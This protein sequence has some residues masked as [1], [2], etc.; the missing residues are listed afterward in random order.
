MSER[1]ANKKVFVFPHLDLINCFLKDEASATCNLESNIVQELILTHYLNSNHDIAFSIKSYLFNG[2]NGIAEAGKS[3]FSQF[4]SLPECVDDTAFPLV[5]FY[6]K[7]ERHFPT[8][9]NASNVNFTH[10]IRCLEDLKDVFEYH[11]SSEKFTVTTSDEKTISLYDLRFEVKS[12]DE[13]I[14]VFHSE[15]KV[16]PIGSISHILDIICKYWLLP[17]PD[18]RPLRNFTFLYRFLSDL[19]SIATYPSTPELRFELVKIA[20]QINFFDSSRI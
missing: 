13:I 17:L 11:S 5:D 16:Y 6:R 12:F 9:L 15:K 1:K 2:E 7:I 19:M 8:D 4:A 20:K 10:F 14:E 18:G 3:L